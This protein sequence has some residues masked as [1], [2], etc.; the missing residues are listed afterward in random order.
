MTQEGHLK[1][2]ENKIVDTNYCILQKFVAVWM[3]INYNSLLESNIV[4]FWSRYKLRNLREKRYFEAPESESM[5]FRVTAWSRINS[6]SSSVFSPSFNWHQKWESW[7]SGKDDRWASCKFQWL[8]V[9]LSDLSLF[10]CLIVSC[11]FM[12]LQSTVGLTDIEHTSWYNDHV[13][14]HVNPEIG[15]SL[16]TGKWLPL[17]PPSCTSCTPL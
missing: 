14:R 9:G 7:P 1:T 4:L 13:M 10:C 16:I 5:S 15:V 12:R 8:A 6:T 17:P 2:Q 3:V 11:S